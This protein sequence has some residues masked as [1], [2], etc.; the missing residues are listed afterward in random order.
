MALVSKVSLDDSQL[1]AAA[2]R[3]EASFERVEK[4]AKQMGSSLAQ[5]GRSGRRFSGSMGEAQFAVQGLSF[6]INDASQ[7]QFGFS[8]LMRATAN[9]VGPVIQG[10]SRM[11]GGA[12]A[13]RAALAGP[14]GVILAFEVVSTAFQLFAARTKDAT[15][16]IADLSAASVGLVLPE[17]RKFEFDPTKALGAIKIAEEDIKRLNEALDTTSKIISRTSGGGRGTFV[18][19]PVRD[20]ISA[21]GLA[22]Y[23]KLIAKNQEL[24]K[25]YTATIAKVKALKERN[26]QL[27]ISFEEVERKTRAAKTTLSEIGLNAKAFGDSFRAPEVDAFVLKMAKVAGGGIEA[28]N[29]LAQMTETLRVLGLELGRINLLP[30]QI[31]PGKSG[32]NEFL[33]PSAETQARLDVARQT[34]DNIARSMGD[35]AALT[36]D[37]ATGTVSAGEAFREFGDIAANV[38]RRLLADIAFATARLAIFKFLLNTLGLATGGGLFGA[39]IRTL[40]GQAGVSSRT[41]TAP[42]TL[43]GPA[44]VAGGVRIIVLQPIIDYDGLRVRLAESQF[45]RSL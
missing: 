25:D 10:F 9:N 21:E 32:L 6:L 12:K 2:K 7:A 8:Q 19:I 1:S 23:D 14:F 13:L 38:F 17:L 41:T 45:N 43:A 15:K 5:T 11:S 27:A 44:T 28:S 39:V 22:A 35:A 36:F 3:A 33:R 20:V 31:R 29:I 40:A 4:G 37:F 34:I 26:D 42:Q 30:P 24:I 18:E 16:D